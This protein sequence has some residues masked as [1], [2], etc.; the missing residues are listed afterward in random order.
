ML[1]DEEILQLLELAVGVHHAVLPCHPASLHGRWGNTP[2]GLLRR[3]HQSFRVFG[4][5]LGCLRERGL[6]GGEWQR[7][8]DSVLHKNVD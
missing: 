5:V 1:G 8:G 3:S 2:H 7:R 6:A 4:C